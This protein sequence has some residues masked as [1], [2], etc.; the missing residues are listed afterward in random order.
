MVLISVFVR[1]FMLPNP[2][3]QLPKR[4]AMTLSGVEVALPPAL[5]NWLAEPVLH[6]ITFAI[7]GLYYTRGIDPAAMGSLLYLLFYCVH[8][9]LLACLAKFEFSGISMFVILWLCSA[10]YWFCNTKKSLVI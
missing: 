1:Q 9:A 8:I 6:A 7:V 4:I 10:A 2:F 3:E 5:L